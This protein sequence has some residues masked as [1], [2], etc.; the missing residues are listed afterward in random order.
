MRISEISLPARK[1]TAFPTP[2]ESSRGA[3]LSLDAIVVSTTIACPTAMAAFKAG[4]QCA[5]QSAAS[6]TF[7]NCQ[8]T[9]SFFHPLHHKLSYR[10]PCFRYPD[11]TLLLS[12]IGLELLHEC[13]CME[14]KKMVVVFVKID[15]PPFSRYPEPLLTEF[16]PGPFK[17]ASKVFEL[18][19]RNL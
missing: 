3:A 1:V 12:F 4:V 18:G 10:G 17:S 9:L 13:P 15:G 14:L 5:N 8:V 19:L 2:V 11:L 7:K 16:D 6:D